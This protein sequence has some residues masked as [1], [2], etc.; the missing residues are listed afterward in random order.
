MDRFL[1][2]YF[3]VSKADMF[4]IQWGYEM[5]IITYFGEPE[6]TERV[7]PHLHQGQLAQSNCN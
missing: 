5:K 1:I 2:A 3:S 4:T 6:I 7:R